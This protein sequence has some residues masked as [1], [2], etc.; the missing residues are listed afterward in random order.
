MK[1]KSLFVSVAIYI[2]TLVA[3]SYADDLA[4]TKTF[5]AGDLTDDT[6]IEIPTNAA[7]VTALNDVK[8]SA[9]A[10][11]D[12]IK[13]VSNNVVQIN[14]DLQNLS[15][16]LP[17]TYF[18]KTE[19]EELLKDKAPKSWGTLDP[20]TGKEQIDG[21]IS[22]SAPTILVAGG[23]TYQKTISTACTYFVLTDNGSGTILGYG[24]NG[25]FRISDSDGV[26]C[27]E[28]VK[29]E[30]RLFGCVPA[31]VHL[32]D[33][34]TS[35]IV[36]Y[37]VNTSNGNPPKCEASLDLLNDT[38]KSEDDESC[39]ATVQWTGAN[40]NWTATITPKQNTTQLFAR[41]F[42]EVGGDTI[43]RNLVPVQIPKIVVGG[44]S[45]S[46][47]NATINGKNVLVLEN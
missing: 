32:D 46:L 12:S 37:N 30:K 9:S 20:M 19:T 45:Y 1:F 3:L 14:D 21:V 13:S 10:N 22:L 38:F 47:T 11:R 43:I 5:V 4:K 42:V 31:S 6:F 24:E 7:S 33:S 35:L 15:I 28:I 29:G 39:G 23:L 41:A 36:V 18:N 27:L 40:G 26:G 34:K 25:Y 16:Y 8:A 44:I 2:G 17:K